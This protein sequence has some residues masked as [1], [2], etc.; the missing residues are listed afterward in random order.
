[1]IYSFTSHQHVAYDGKN[2]FFPHVE[3]NNMFFKG[4]KKKE[5]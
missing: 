1:M 5:V 2:N 4:E 3:K